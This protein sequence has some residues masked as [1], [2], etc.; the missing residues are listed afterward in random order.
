MIEPRLTGG[1]GFFPC[2]PVIDAGRLVPRSR[3][4]SP[5]QPGSA[6]SKRLAKLVTALGSQRRPGKADS[7][8]LESLALLVWPQGGPFVEQAVTALESAVRW[9]PADAKLWSDL[10]AAYSVRAVERDN[11]Y[12]LVLA[13]EAADRAIA[14]NRLLPEARFNRALTLEALGLRSEAWSA[15]QDYL[16][17]DIESGWAGEARARAQAL[18]QT[19]IAPWE[20]Q[21][22]FLDAAALRG[23]QAG[24]TRIVDPYRQAARERTEQQLLGLWGEARRGGKPAEADRWLTI[25]R[26]VG[27]SLAALGGDSLARDAVAAVDEASADRDDRRLE[28][29]AEGYLAFREGFVLYKKYDTDRAIARLRQARTALVQ[30]RSPFAERAAFFLACADYH[31]DHIREAHA[32]LEELSQRVAG[33]P[34]PSLLG[35]IYWMQGLLRIYLGE[36]DPMRV[37]SDYARS[38][39]YFQTAGDT[40]NVAVLQSLIAENLER[41][42]QTS[43]AWEHGLVSARLA[44][45]IRDPQLQ[46]IV[47][48]TA[49]GILQKERPTIALY[50]LNA[51]VRQMARTE[52]PVLQ[53][54]ALLRRGLLHSRM[55]QRA[56][57]TQD[58]QRTGSVIGRESDPK[59]RRD[60]EADLS[61]MEGE[62]L[63]ESDPGKAA[64][65]LTSALA[66]YE[67][68]QNYLFRLMARRARAHA[69]RA[70]H[71]LELAAA[72]LL[73]G[74]EAYEKL[75]EDLHTEAWRAGFV[76]R[77]DDIFREMISFQAV[78]R[79]RADL[80]FAFADRARTRVLPGAAS[81]LPAGLRG[82]ARLLP[83]E[84]E[85]V[86]L[87]AIQKALP[88]STVL[89]QYAALEDR[90]LIWLVH[91][92]GFVPFTVPITAAEL[93]VLVVRVQSFSGGSAWEQAAKSLH[94]RLV[95]PWQN[96][97]AP[98]DR[99]VFVP[100]GL[101]DGLP[102]ACLRDPR[103]GRYLLEDHEISQVPSATIYA[104][105]SETTQGSR[106][107]EGPGLV[108]G[109]P[110][111]DLPAAEGEA[112]QIAS[113]YPG[114][115]LLLG[116][117][118][119]KRDFLRQSRLSGWIH[120]AGH[121]ITNGENPLLSMLLLAPATDRSDTGALYAREIYEL[122]LRG[123]RLVVLAACD[124]AADRSKGG[125]A[126]LARAFLAAGV[127]TVIASFWRVDDRVTSELFATFYDRLRAGDDPAAALRAAQLRLLRGSD[128]LLQ[129]PSS[130]GAFAM[131]GANAL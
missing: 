91:R 30:A 17:L 28:L 9:K 97:V 84:G 116:V 127:P 62:L 48:G 67:E 130:W 117:A 78:E 72:D 73:A 75:G 119:T 52:N 128:R 65:L 24:V 8:H 102:F 19:A 61:L 112:R 46:Y 54:S 105:A 15:W 7:Q 68:N 20:S 5:P 63:L 2:T 26:V 100:D 77:T 69:Y 96:L 13:L 109:N 29:L 114:S 107:A 35:H 37:Q 59:I 121:A 22:G 85:P 129:R 18:S 10:A 16:A 36:G 27:K 55:G 92:D 110:T 11:P 79:R 56:Q 81:A 40:D 120:F 93:R 125:G 12:D 39:T 106:S 41:L 21:I 126:S 23:D 115:R 44:P 51:L 80:A 113:L 25:A 1:F 42:G 104:R 49:F 111:L 43:A 71:Q 64:A 32:A 50:F 3:C 4:A 90:L 83:A 124:S 14:M 31:R 70:T 108:V 99:I 88:Q 98:A 76:A 33:R 118:A 101:L 45:R 89:I 60:L 38:L 34:Y 87:R 47:L 66:V 123:T 58:F 82:E 103:T 122:K 74:L 94:E 95:R 53:A 86:G 6:E 57:A 131:I